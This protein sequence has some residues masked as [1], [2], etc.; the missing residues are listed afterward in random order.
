MIGKGNYVDTY[1]YVG[2]P[3]FQAW[4]HEQHPPT[5]IKSEV[6]EGRTTFPELPEA[7]RPNFKEKVVRLKEPQKPKKQVPVRAE[8]EDVEEDS[9]E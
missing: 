6:I 1:K 7:E 3:A 8:E 4:F 5:E 9:T 2:L